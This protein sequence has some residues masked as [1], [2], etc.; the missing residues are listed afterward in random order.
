METAVSLTSEG[1]YEAESILFK[2]STSSMWSSTRVG[3]R[4][5]TT[6]CAVD[7]ILSSG[8]TPSLPFTLRPYGESTGV[9]LRKKRLCL[10]AEPSWATVC[11]RVGLEV[12]RRCA[13]GSNVREVRTC[14]TFCF[15]SDFLQLTL[16]E[17][18][19]HDDRASYRPWNTSVIR[20]EWRESFSMSACMCMYIF[21]CKS[22]QC[23]HVSLSRMCVCVCVFADFFRHTYTYI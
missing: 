17:S 3:S 14:L 13:S 11:T 8:H 12:S 10:F 6:S 15:E 19:S 4:P 9:V 23:I 20:P 18:R 7:L 21:A 1:S 2:V 5:S 16:S 22:T